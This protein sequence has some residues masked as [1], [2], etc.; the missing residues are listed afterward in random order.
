MPKSFKLTL[1]EALD[2]IL[3]LHPTAKESKSLT[4][5]RPKG[6]ANLEFRPDPNGDFVAYGP[7][8]GY[9][10]LKYNARSNKITISRKY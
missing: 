2:E 9:M 6:F 4:R 7:N 10:L 5:S 3:K 1:Y 8:G